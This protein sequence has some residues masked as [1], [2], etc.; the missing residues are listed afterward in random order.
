VKT[1]LQAAFHN[2]DATKGVC[3]DCHK[4]EN[5]KNFSNDIE[6]ARSLLPRHQATIDIAKAQ[7]VYGKDPEMRELAQ[8][9]IH[10]EQGEM[11]QIQR[12]L[13]QHDAANWAPVK[14]RDCH[15][16]AESSP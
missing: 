13:K 2:V 14:C 16:K 9:I 8:G 7:L 10:D 12:W 15:K 4:T 3:I 6:F 5:S 1:G 11:E